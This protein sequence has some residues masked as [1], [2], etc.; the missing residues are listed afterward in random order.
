MMLLP[1]CRGVCANPGPKIQRSPS[2]SQP[3]IID[4]HDQATT[5]QPPDRLSNLS[6]D[7]N[8]LSINPALFDLDPDAPPPPKITSEAV[9]T[10][11]ITELFVSAAKSE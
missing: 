1:P 4:D 6:Q 11:D 5:W 8:G 9:V 2:A 3:Q 7:F 10:T